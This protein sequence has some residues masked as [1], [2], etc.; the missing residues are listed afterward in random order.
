M[1]AS[2]RRSVLAVVIASVMSPCLAIAQQPAGDEIQVLK[3]EIRRL[4]ERLERLER[5]QSAGP[6]STT[7]QTAPSGT[8][9]AAPSPPPPSL[10]AQTPPPGPRPPAPPAGE[11]E[12]QLGGEHPLELLGMSRPDV[13]GF[14]FSGFFAGS[15]SY[16]S[17]IQMVPEF[18]G[19]GQAL[20]DPRSVNFRFDKFSFGVSRTFASW[21]SAAASVEV[22]SHRDRH[23]HLATAGAFGCPPGLACERFGAEASETEIDLHRLAITGVV[24]IGNGLTIAFGRFDTPFGIERHDQN[25]LFTATNSELFRFGRANSMTGF[26]FSYPFAPWLDVTAWVANRWE[27]ETTHD[28]FDDNNRAKSFGGRIGVTPFAGGGRLLNVGLGGWWGEEQTDDTANP[29]WIVDLD[30]TWSPLARLVLAGEF[31]YGAEDDVSFRARGVPFA[32]PA[33][34][35]KDVSWWGLYALAH[36]DLYDWLGLTFRYGFFRDDDAARTGVEQSLQ[37]F[38]VAP[39]LHLSRLVPGL[40]PLGVTYPRTAHPLN[41]VD[42]KLEY[43]ANHSNRPVFSDARP[44]VSILDAEHWSHEVQ[45]QFVVNY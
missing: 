26:Q 25:L 15:A 38:T 17:G 1:R 18:A 8:V 40:R 42:L 9:P 12:I 32:A 30:V 41:W 24:P 19:G 31:L 20:S 6:P 45:L 10:T 13:S 5:N 7:V 43:R 16:N 35:G 14:R 22:E 36:Y 33:V 44:N 23:T 3:Q 28:P 11:R 2:H 29:R 37:S 27:N 4:Q 39:V 34:V 21:L